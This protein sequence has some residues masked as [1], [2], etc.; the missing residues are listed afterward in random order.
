MFKN[1]I[2]TAWRN[3]WFNKVSSIV[4]VVGLTLG[5]TCFLL[6]STYLINELRYDR[7]HANADRI[8]RI[9]TNSKGTSD[10]DVSASAVTPTAPVPVFKDAFSEVED[11]VRVYNYSGEGGAAVK[12]K[13]KLFS[14]KRMLLADE[15]FFKVFSF[16]FLAGNPA[17]ALSNPESVVITKYTAQKYFGKENPIGKVLTVN[18][19][20]NM[21][22]TGVIEDVPAYSHIKFNIMGTYSMLDH[23]KT[24]LWDSANDYSYLL[25]K[26][27]TKV[28]AFENKVNAYLKD[29]L[30]E[31]VTDS[32][33]WYTLEPLTDIH[34]RSATKFGLETS[35]NSTQVNILAVIAGIMLLM[36][37]I[38]FLNLATARSADRAHEIGVRKVM[39][40]MKGQLFSQFMMEAAMVTLFSI[41][42][43]V[44]ITALSF[45]WF[46][47]FAGR[48]VNFETWK[49]IWLAAV[50]I[51]LFAI[52]TVMAGTYP[53]LYLSSFKP[54]STL[55]KKASTGVL[56]MSIRK[57][58]V[59]VQFVVSVFFITCTLIAGK[60]LKY[61]QQK[62]TGFNRSQVVVINTG[63]MPYSQI[64]A[65]NGQ[66][67]RLNGVQQASASYD[68]PVNI[69]GSYSING[70][71]GKPSN[72]ELLV[73]AIAAERNFA[74]TLGMH[75]IAGSNF[76]PGDALQVQKQGFENRSYSF[77]INETAV[78]ALGWKPVESIGKTIVMGNRKGEVRAVVRDFNFASLHESITPVI[79]F[80]EYDWMGKIMI[81]V[82]GSNTKQVIN[83]INQSW[84]SFYPNIPFE[85][86]FLDQ[87]FNDLYV[88]EQRTGAILNI[89]TLVTIIIS[90]LGLFGLAVYTVK[91]RVKEIGI[92][93]ILGAS[94][95][96]VLTLVA[97]D[98]LKLVIAAVIVASPV[99]WLVM[100]NWLQDFAYRI[101][102]SWWMFAQAALYTLLIAVITVSFQS[103][104]VALSNPVKSLRSE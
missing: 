14:E 26:S 55:G 54:I 44:G 27:N 47:N 57:S 7:F 9:I 92:R 74:P 39:G 3:L 8:V 43:G 94:V 73:T 75:V 42:I 77:V 30:K 95:S 53:S 56:G 86:H 100:N 63:G 91:Q 80:P 11:G 103:V 45:G 98:F 102:I 2:K 62:D 71:T 50:L 68:S 97:L 12:F 15:S 38:N 34:L 93:K 81:R 18:T 10:A 66:I 70:A 46:S 72:Y 4:S 51:G 76:T 90:C 23:S 82:S 89:F 65:F 88:S 60:Q 35:G 40:A 6:L 87:E 101:Q 16:K 85:Y 17:N 13:D 61:I 32:K 58:L 64:E 78:K 33:L 59:V 48:E 52:V 83:G 96:S 41:I 69:K 84:K 31:K 1:Y 37:C 19:K 67:S 20:R 25:L 79:I 24:R 22:I 49:P 5:V 104:T 28:N 29:A 21:V 99:A 36:A